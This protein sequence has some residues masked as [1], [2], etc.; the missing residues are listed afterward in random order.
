MFQNTWNNT[1]PLVVYFF[2]ITLSCQSSFLLRHCKDNLNIDIGTV[3]I[4]I[5]S[6]SFIRIKTLWFTERKAPD[7]RIYVRVQTGFK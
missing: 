1:A 4:D 2:Q 6:V 3:D 5:Y 7:R